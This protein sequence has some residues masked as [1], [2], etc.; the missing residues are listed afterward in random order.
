M[1]K[2]TYIILAICIAL[3]VAL[4]IAICASKKTDTNKTDT[5]ENPF[6]NYSP[7]EF[8]Q[9]DTEIMEAVRM[10]G[11]LPSAENLTEAEKRFYKKEVINAISMMDIERLKL[12]LDEASIKVFE[13]IESEVK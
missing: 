3:I 9:L 6:E 11:S 8:E 10:N 2:K 7:E 5:T 1:K 12:Y 4:V 13:E